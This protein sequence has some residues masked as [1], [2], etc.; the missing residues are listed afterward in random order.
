MGGGTSER[1]P[2]GYENLQH[3]VGCQ[4]AS[5]VA[6]KESLI[7]T[8]TSRLSVSADL[9][10]SRFPLNLSNCKHVNSFNLISQSSNC[11]QN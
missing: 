8:K 3:V 2:R 1:A 10:M 11:L 4:A 6:S 9:W 7:R 5:S